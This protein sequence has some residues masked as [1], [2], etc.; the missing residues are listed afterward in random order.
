MSTLQWLYPNSL[1]ELRECLQNDTLLHGGGT[2][3]MRNPP[4][5]G[6]VADL[7]RV[8]I[9]GVERVA[10]GMRLGGAARFA[11]VIQALNRSDHL[12]A[13]ALSD[14]ASPALRN[15]ITLGGSIALFPPWSSV[16]GPLIALEARLQLVGQHEA[17][18]SISDYL[19][20]RELGK[21]TAI[22]A[23]EVDTATAWTS[24]WFRFSRTHFNYPLFTVTVLTQVEG[25]S[26]S[27]ARIVLTG[28]RGRYKRL[29][30]LEREVVGGSPPEHIDAN[31]LATDVP[32][33]Q[34]F[35][36]AYLT[37]VAAVE[38][39]R[40]LRAGFGGAS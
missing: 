10:D 4:R 25:R 3:L 11:D 6:S 29:T 8:G 40:G 28:N 34:G 20:N 24:Y 37:H 2:G 21:G 38:V 17:W 23:V 5:K 19:D 1:D 32:D 22:A 9:G 18:V 15:R 14:A 39:T 36:G 35:T 26:L 7:S 13:K 27:T 31:Q 16:V 12:L 30:E 33:R